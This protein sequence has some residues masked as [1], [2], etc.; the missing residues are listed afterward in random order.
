MEHYPTMSNE[1]KN[2]NSLFHVTHH[3]YI[4]WKRSHR[5]KNEQVYTKR[6]FL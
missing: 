2:T 1:R 3:K 4:Q 6:R 5:K